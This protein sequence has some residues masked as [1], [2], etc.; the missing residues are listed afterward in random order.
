MTKIASSGADGLQRS[1]WNTLP[2]RQRGMFYIVHDVPEL[3]GW[4]EGLGRTFCWKRARERQ[5]DADI[6]PM[7]DKQYGY[8]GEMH[9]TK[10]PQ[11]TPT[12]FCVPRQIY[13]SMATVTH[14]VKYRCEL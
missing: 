4:D 14:R 2:T 11:C 1:S 3:T 6:Q 7:S 12:P 8:T 10:R 13:L 5:S 9:R